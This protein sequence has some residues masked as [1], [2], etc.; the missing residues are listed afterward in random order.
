MSGRRRCAWPFSSQ[1]RA[2]FPRCVWFSRVVA[3][4]FSPCRIFLSVNHFH[5]VERL[6][7]GKMIVIQGSL[8]AGIA[9]WFAH[10]VIGHPQPFFAPMAAV[11]ALGTS[12]VG[13]LR[14]SVELVM[15][16]SLGIGIGDI[17]ISHIGTGSWQIAITVACALAAALFL[18]KSP[19]APIQATCSAVLVA[20][21]MPPGTMGGITRM[22]D[23]L[24]GGLIGIMVIAL[25]PNSA[26]RP[27]RR[28]VSRVIG[29]AG[30]VARSSE[31]RRGSRLRR[32]SV[33]P[34]NPGA[35]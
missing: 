32:F 12:T 2:V 9:F 35:H 16:V 4:F 21:I 8:A 13:R 23:A 14:R 34:R 15:G 30:H 31:Q 17:M 27:A 25:V 24:V 6:S 20:T 26:I 3:E 22:I 11:I 19:L 33:R 5:G 29:H 7:D 10:H 1:L 18:D 28:E